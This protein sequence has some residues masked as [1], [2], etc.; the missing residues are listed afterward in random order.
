MN[1]ATPRLHRLSKATARRRRMRR[2]MTEQARPL[3]HD[4]LRGAAYAAGGGI[5][6]LLT[7]WVQ[8]WH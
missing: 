6:T 8:T 3:W 2:Q 1:D 4:L 5:V 7:A